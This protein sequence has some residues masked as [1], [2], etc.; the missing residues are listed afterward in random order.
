MRLGII[1]LFPRPGLK[2]RPTLLLSINTS[3]GDGARAPPYITMSNDSQSWARQ[4]GSKL[5]AIGILTAL[6]AVPL[7]LVGMVTSER[8]T[9]QQQVQDEIG[10]QWGGNQRII[11]P[12]L[13]VRFSNRKEETEGDGKT[14]WVG[15]NGYGTRWTREAVFLPDTLNIKGNVSTEQRHRGIYEV[16]ALRAALQVDGTFEL[17]DLS[18]QIGSDVAIESAFI[19]F[20]VTDPRGLEQQIKASWNGKGMEFEPGRVESTAIA[21]S[22]I[23]DLDEVPEAGSR[24][25]FKIDLKLKGSG[26]LAFVP[27]ARQS[28]IELVSDWPHPSFSGAF[29][30][31]EHNVDAKGFSASWTI[32]RI[33]Q[34]HPQFWLKSDSWTTAYAPI[35]KKQSFGVRFYEPANTYQQVHRAL[36]YAIL[37]IGLAFAAFFV[38]EVTASKSI[39]VV[40]YLM[41]GLSQAIFYL[42]VLALS[43]HIGFTR[44]YVIAALACIGLVA[45]YTRS[46]LENTGLAVL[47]AALLA[48]L[49]GVL[50]A[51]LQLADYALLVGSGTLF[52]ALAALMYFTRNVDWDK[53][54][55]GFGPRRPAATELPPEPG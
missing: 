25:S 48:C 3:K 21:G 31:N 17:P 2:A 24:A 1:P 55:K 6:M 41:I 28:E 23:A 51:V 8:E 7:A 22:L 53:A 37:F 42:L 20:K 10:R 29:L 46:V 54:S 33:A 52:A 30:P 38:I 45:F 40:Q 26:Q 50:H 4:P 16:V 27:L 12:I 15:A 43:E 14:G 18:E 32:P 34:D 36:K 47:V 49:Y 5:V 19:S 44:A 11:G 13:T 35:L 39:H 9:Y